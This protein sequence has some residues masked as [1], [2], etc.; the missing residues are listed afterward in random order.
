[1]YYDILYHI[2]LYDF[3]LQNSG[4]TAIPLDPSLQHNTQLQEAN[5]NLD[6]ILANAADVFKNLQDQHSIL[7]V[8]LC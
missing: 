1:M 4:Q 2:V 7:K 5:R 6:G 3:L 8:S